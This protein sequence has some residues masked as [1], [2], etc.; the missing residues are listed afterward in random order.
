MTVTATGSGSSDSAEDIKNKLESLSVGQRLDTD[1]VDE[2]ANRKFISAQDKSKLD[3]A[4]THASQSPEDDHV[5]VWFNG[6][7]K[8]LQD[9]KIEHINV[10]DGVNASS[11]VKTLLFPGHQA[12]GSGDEA[13]IHIECLHFATKAELDAWA[14][15]FGRVMDFD[16]VAVV[17]DDGNGFVGWYKFNAA[18]KKVE[19]YDA[20][21]VVMSDSNGAIP[22]NIKTVVFGPGF[23]IKQAGD[24]EDAALV[25]FTEGG[26]SG[27][28]GI[29]ID[30]HKVTEFDIGPNL[31]FDTGIGTGGTA[32]L[33]VNPR[34]FEVQHAAS[35]LL[36]LDSD[37]TL[38]NGRETKLYTSH[39]IIPTGE[40]YS[41]NQAAGGVNVQDNTGGDTA[42]TGGELTRI[43]GSVSFYGKASDA[44]NVKLWFEYK[45]PGN[46]LPA[47]ILEDVNGNPMV[48][49]RHYNQGDSLEV[50]LVI[51][52]A[53]MATGQAPIVMKVEASAGSFVVNPDQTLICVE[54]FSDGYET[55]L[56]SIEFQRR[57]GIESH[58]EIKQ[59]STTMLSLSDE[60]YTDEPETSVP[61]NYGYDFLNEFGVQNLT[62]IKAAISNNHL[63]IS[64]D[65]V[66][67]D[68]Y[69]DAYLDNVKTSMLRGK[70]IDY[71]VTIKNPHDAYNLEVYKWTG[72]PDSAGRVYDS[73][74]NDA[75]VL[76]DGF[77]LV[78][79]KFIAEQP[80]GNATGVTDS[81]V[82]PTDAKNIFI[83]LRPAVAQS[84]INLTLQEFKWGVPQPFR[85]YWETSRVNL[86]EQH[87]KYSENWAEFILTSHTIGAA[88][89]R[90]TINNTPSSGN[91]MPV[92]KLL[93]GAAPVEIDNTVN[94]VSGS[95]DPQYDGGIK[96]LKDGEASISKSYNLWNEQG[97]DNTVTFWDVLIDADGNESKI[98]DSERTFTVPKNTGAPGVIY[99]IPAYVVQ[100]E[101][102]QR[103]AG[104]ATSNK[105][106]GVYVQS[107]NISQLLVQTEIDFKELV[108]TSSDD[109]D[110]VSSPIPKANV[111]DRRVYSFTGN[112]AQ[113]VEIDLDIPDDVEL[114]EIEVVKHS[115]TK[116]T[117]IKDCEYAYDSATNKL[118]VHVGN[119]VSD[120][121]VYLTFWSGVA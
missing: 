17:D 20:Q 105:A 117:S 72:K 25:T 14:A 76:N 112:T 97:T 41:L 35:C 28:D 89:L 108:A 53:M 96:F 77:T 91:P 73:R 45:E 87:L 111:F 6:E 78:K 114:A 109:P 11:G 59:F 57:T 13:S 81:V 26:G 40:Y 98:D 30:G 102:G 54:Q 113:N 80:T 23:A 31:Q 63:I 65:G 15:K 74:N 51:A 88:S 3:K 107:Q 68:F 44:G 29:T 58:A 90:Y 49:E 34:S 52:G 110:L 70:T 37:I 36:Q 43:L 83:I 19:E 21:G 55:S 85:G 16:S 92:G 27:I 95:A 93:K 62:K 56:A 46:P 94:Q 5:A 64:D 1:H 115:G 101:T 7:L 106:D 38:T 9:D 33:L 104:R 48:V 103:V 121:K 84:P 8:A 120:G 24:Q 82:V 47:S 116:T 18:T 75:L 10:G 67:A 69:I 118:T 22:K 2:T 39:E 4:V 60:L 79:S 86:N 99:S 100:V 119:A 61:A 12:Y 66:I 32:R 50:P 71:D 42:V